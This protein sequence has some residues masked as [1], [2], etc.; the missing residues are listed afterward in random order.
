ML[1]QAGWC[2]NDKRVERIWQREGLK[3]PPKQKKRGRLS[4]APLVTSLRDALPDNGR[5]MRAL[6]PGTT[7]PRLVL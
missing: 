4:L 6:A 1:V 5:L 2:V 7:E 3:V